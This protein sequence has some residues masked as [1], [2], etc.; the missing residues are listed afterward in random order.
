MLK[1]ERIWGEGCLE[2]WSSW[3]GLK[4]I[5]KYFNIEDL[6]SNIDFENWKNIYFYLNL[7]QNDI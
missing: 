4:S 6:N 7:L 1:Y 3:K 2:D 5:E